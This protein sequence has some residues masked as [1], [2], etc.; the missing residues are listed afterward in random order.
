[1][2]DGDDL[3]VSGWGATQYE[4]GSSK[5]L[6]EVQVDFVPNSDCSASYGF[7]MDDASLC[8]SSPGKDA[9]QGDSGGP[10][11]V[12]ESDDGSASSNDILVGVVSYGFECANPDYPG[13]YARVQYVF[14]W[15]Q[16]VLCDD[17]SSSGVVSEYCGPITPT[18]PAPTISHKPTQVP[19]LCTDV[20]NFI[21]SYGD[22][23]TFYEENDIQGCPV[24]SDCQSCNVG[25]GTP[26]EACCWCGGGNEGPVG[27]STP[28]PTIFCEDYPQYTD[29]FGDSCS[30]YET[31]T[32][33]G[34]GTLA[35]CCSSELGTPGEACCW[36]S[37]GIIGE[38]TPTT[39]PPTKLPTKSP[40]QS[41]TKNPTRPPTKSPSQSPIKTPTQSPTR[42]L[43]DSPTKNP[44]RPPTKSPSRSPTKNPTQFPTKKPSSSPI[45]LPQ[46]E[47]PTKKPTLSPTESPTQFPT[48]RPSSSPVAMPMTS[49]QTVHVPPTGRPSQAFTTTSP[50]ESSTQSPAK[51]PSTSPV[52]IPMTSPQ[53]MPPTGSPTESFTSF[54]TRSPS[55]SLIDL[56]ISDSPTLFPT[57]SEKLTSFPTTTSTRQP[58]EFSKNLPTSGPSLKAISASPTLQDSHPPSNMVTTLPTLDFPSYLP[59]P[60]ISIQSFM[61]LSF[62]GLVFPLSEKSSDDLEASIKKLIVDNVSSD[63]GMEILSVSQVTDLSRRSD[64]SIASSDIKFSITAK[65]LAS[66][67]VLDTAKVA[68]ICSNIVNENSEELVSLL[69][70]SDEAFSKLSDIDAIFSPSVV[71]SDIPTQ[72]SNA[73]TLK[74]TPNNS[75]SKNCSS[76]V[77]GQVVLVSVWI[78]LFCA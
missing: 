24:W 29:S 55:V 28:A 4:G 23:C 66:S 6:L 33:N 9:C 45:M 31:N 19:T 63:D 37:G 49:P 42:S 57:N 40:T 30:W 2:T 25:F 75:V 20:P 26:G 65:L 58:S 34:C 48:K 8:A 17:W 51:K 11:V 60:S 70:Q 68:D 53:T 15:I 50:T 5:L 52:T 54:T 46:T 62:L 59:S 12:R 56:P 47:S 74:S 44:T 67:T 3:F 36:C 41:P 1:L 43:T 69:V 38:I 22:D 32:V 13:V 27:P 64:S 39:L 18:T 71:P 35:D 16:S 72:A 73:P 61:T 7:S 10:L 78:L 76:F 21:D 77:L 14:D